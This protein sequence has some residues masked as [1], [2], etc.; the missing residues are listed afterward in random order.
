MLNKDGTMIA[1]DK[2][3]QPIPTYTNKDVMNFARGFTNF[4]HQGNASVIM[5]LSFALLKLNIIS[6]LMSC[7]PED[8]RD[9][10]ELEWS[11]AWIPNA[12]DP[13]YLPSSEGRVRISLALSFQK[14]IIVSTILLRRLSR[15]FF[16]SKH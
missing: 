16:Q 5:C 15:I 1:D 6:L 13:M 9:N 12:V 3:G 14:C 11:L 10:I 8:E 4:A 7:T 2:T